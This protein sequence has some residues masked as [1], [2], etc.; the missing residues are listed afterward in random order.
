M[1][2]QP[3]R[4][5]SGL[6][7]VF[8]PSEAE[9]GRPTERPHISFALSGGITEASWNAQAKAADFYA[10]K[11]IVENLLAQYQDLSFVASSDKAGMHPGRTAS[12]KIADQEI[13]FV[14]QIHPATAKKYDIKETYVGELDLQVMLELAPAQVIF[15]DLPK[16]QA[17]SRDLSLLVD[18]TVTHDQIRQT[19]LES[20]VKTSMQSNWR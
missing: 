20:R 5:T 12:V 6:G 7:N 2:A 9:D 14:G 4:S 11:G 10:A 13:G 1:T 18:E 16:V 3:A 19:V 15:K 17:S 8:L